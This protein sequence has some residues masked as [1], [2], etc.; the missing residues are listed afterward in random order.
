MKSFT[1]LCLVF[2]SLW[3]LIVILGFQL[4]LLVL[5]TIDETKNALE[6]EWKAATERVTFSGKSDLGVFIMTEDCLFL[7][8]VLNV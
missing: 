2:L 8:D 5:D 3:Q 7:H 6:D 4:D 1:V